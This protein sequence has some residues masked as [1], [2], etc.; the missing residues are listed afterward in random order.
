MYDVDVYYDVNDVYFFYTCYDKRLMNQTQ[1]VRHTQ[2][3]TLQD[4][5]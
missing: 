4:I 5:S 2:H 1:T 3:N